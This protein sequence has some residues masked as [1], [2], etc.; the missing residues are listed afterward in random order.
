MDKG[1]ETDMS[2]PMGAGAVVS[3]PS[4][5]V[6]F[7]ENLFAKKINESSLNQ[8]TTI[9]DNY[10][11]G[12]FKIP[13]QD[14]RFGHEGGIDEFRSVLYYFPT[15]KVAVALTSNGKTTITVIL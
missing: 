4:D 8:M 7:I 11:M 13:F 10:G 14:K 6:L 1:T 5:L 3:N 9:Q 15:D 12:V 2:I